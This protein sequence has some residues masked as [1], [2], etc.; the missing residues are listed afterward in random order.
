MLCFVI[1][2]RFQVIHASLN[3][4]NSGWHSLTAHH[5]YC[6][7]HMGSNFNTIFKFVEDKRYLINAAYNPSK[8]GCEWYLDPLRGLSISIEKNRET[9]SKMRVTHYDSLT[10]L[11]SVEEVELLEGWSHTSY[12]VRLNLGTCDYRLFQYLHYLCRHALATCAVVSIEWGTFVDP[13]YQMGSIFKVYQMEFPPI[14]E[15]M[16]SSWY[17]ARLNPNPSMLR[18][19]K[20]RPVLTRLR[21]EIDAMEHS[22]KR[23]GL[24]LQ[25][26]HTR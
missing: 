14:L 10:L 20:E 1:S 3:A 8:E 16:W 26:G 13:A 15:K 19:E 7:H 9:L 12:Y 25:E 6:I 2:D 11:F 4:P 23:C 18:N 5:A 21:N 22:E 24:C 17:G